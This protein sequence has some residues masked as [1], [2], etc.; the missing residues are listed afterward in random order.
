MEMHLENSAGSGGSRPKSL[1]GYEVIDFIGEGAASQIYVVSHPQTKQLYALKHVVRRSEKDDRFIEL[2]RCNVP[3][4][5]SRPR[6]G[7]ESFNDTSAR[8]KRCDQ[9]NTCILER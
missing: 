3:N 7:P 9:R 1:F 5:P 4:L 2:L 8:K 6:S